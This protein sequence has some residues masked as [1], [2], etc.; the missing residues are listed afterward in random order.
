MINGANFWDD[1]DRY[2]KQSNNAVEF[3]LSRYHAKVS[4]VACGP[5]S[6]VNCIA[7]MGEGVDIVTFGGWSAQPEDILTL[8]FHDYR[9]WPRLAQIRKETDPAT[10][11]YSPHEVPQYYPEA[12][13]RVFGM[14][15]QF[16]WGASFDRVVGFVSEGYPI[17]LNHKPD[18]S[19]PGHYVAIVAYD[20]NNDELIYHD[21][22]PEG[23]PSHS[24]WGLRMPRDR[25]AEF[26]DYGVIF[27]GFAE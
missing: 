12:V 22:W 19:K 2:Y 26:E 14:N 9:N 3:I 6:A 27:E 7:A 25:F 24:G 13:K 8:W 11:K 18:R 1:T 20:T 10:S 15:A 4:A 16:S 17:M 21:S 5:S 23:I